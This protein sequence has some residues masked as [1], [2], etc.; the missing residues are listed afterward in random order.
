M[1]Q[2][3]TH[4]FSSSKTLYTASLLSDIIN[5]RR[6]NKRKVRYEEEDEEE[7]ESDW[8]NYS[9]DDEKLIKKINNK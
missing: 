1:L 5:N 3:P 8:E 9:Y 4:Y 2:S 6:K 7:K